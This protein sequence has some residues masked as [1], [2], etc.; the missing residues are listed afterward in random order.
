MTNIKR[1]LL[2]RFVQLKAL[3]VG[4]VILDVY[5]QGQAAGIA[6]EAPVPLLDIS[7][8]WNSLGGAANVAANLAGLGIK[9]HLIGAA[10]QDAAG[11]ILQQLLDSRGITFDPIISERPTIQKTRI[12]S[13]KHYYLRI[14]EEDTSPLSSSEVE[15]LDEKIKAVLPQVNLLIVSD[16]DKGLLTPD[17]SRVIET[18]AQHFQVQLSGDIKPQNIPFWH[19]LNLITPNRQE[20]RTMGIVL[21]LPEIQPGDDAVLARQLSSALNCQVLLT[22]AQEG[23]IAADRGGAPQCLP[24]C[25]K[26]PVNTSGAGD[27][28]LATAAA[29]LAAGAELKDAAWLAGLAASIAVSYEDTHAVTAD[30]LNMALNSLV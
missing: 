5:L 26:N 3:V 28:V 6:N 27:T 14:D 25:S 2:N 4:D 21:Q 23:M 13:D 20:G 16:Y 17:A 8:T 11:A 12:L 7:E 22:L 18:A 9:T 1:E 29:A 30:E 24:A 19:H 10:G 15:A